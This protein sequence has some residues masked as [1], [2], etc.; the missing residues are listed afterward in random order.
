MELGRRALKRGEEA[1][2]TVT[3]GLLDDGRC[4]GAFSVLRVSDSTS[5]GTLVLSSRRVFIA[6]LLG[7]VPVFP[8]MVEQ[9]P[10]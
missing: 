6:I 3:F 5:A 8:S 7:R 9:L 1:T 2:E 4:V 10:Y